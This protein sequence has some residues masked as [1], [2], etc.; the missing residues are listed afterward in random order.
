MLEAVLEP[1]LEQALKKSKAYRFDNQ[2]R[3]ILF[4]RVCFKKALEDCGVFCP[5][6]LKSEV[7]RQ[8]ALKK[9]M[10]VA[11]VRVERSKRMLFDEWWQGLFIFKAGELVAF[12]TEPKMQNPPA[13]STE[14]YPAYTVR[15]NVKL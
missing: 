12:A 6:K 4:M 9:L 10:S 7:E 15:T 8:L 2:P 11:N 3:A 14:K 5:P 13:M 1:M